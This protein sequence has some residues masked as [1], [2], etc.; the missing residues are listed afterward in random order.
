MKEFIMNFKA[1][2][3]GLENITNNV[4]S[5]INLVEKVRDFIVGFTLTN[6]RKYGHKFIQYRFVSEKKV[7][8]KT[9]VTVVES[10]QIALDEL[11]FLFQHKKAI[12]E[13][14]KDDKVEIKVLG[15]SEE[16][17]TI[18]LANQIEMKK[19]YASN[20]KERTSKKT[21]KLSD[22]LKL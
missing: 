19:V 16:Q 9:S 15:L 3:S 22:L 13:L 7:D 14:I 20:K 11:C 1:F 21:L 18:G 10:K 17:M 8:D 5:T 6:E 2:N 12:D 4:K